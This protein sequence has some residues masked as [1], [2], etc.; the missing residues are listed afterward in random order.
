MKKITITIELPH[1][2]ADS[3]QKLINLMDAYG[4]HSKLVDGVYEYVGE[5]EVDV[6]TSVATE[7]AQSIR[8]NASVSVITE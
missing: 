1:V 8:F 7:I 4:M 6:V 2:D 5:T 3:Y